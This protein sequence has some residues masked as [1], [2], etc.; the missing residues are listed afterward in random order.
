MPDKNNSRINK[1]IFSKEL[2]LYFESGQ[3]TKN[4][5]NLLS[6]FDSIPIK[7]VEAERAF[8]T[9]GLLLHKDRSRLKNIKNSII[10]RL[11]YFESG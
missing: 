1:E 4:I 10:L 3:K 6:A 8:S 11:H 5:S 7:S 2:D 9:V